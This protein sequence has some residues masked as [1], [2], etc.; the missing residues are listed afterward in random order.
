MT[1]E[2]PDGQFY[3]V[4]DVS[5]L[6]VQGGDVDQVMLRDQHILPDQTEVYSEGSFFY[7]KNRIIFLLKI[8]IAL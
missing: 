6:D 1:V 3:V 5:H 8:H 7:Q 4:L 2:G